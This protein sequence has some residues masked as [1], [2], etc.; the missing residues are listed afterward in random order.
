MK[1]LVLI[2]FIFPVFFLWGTIVNETVSISGG[3][4][5]LIYTYSEPTIE[6]SLD[7]QVVKDTLFT[8]LKSPDVPYTRMI[9]MPGEREDESLPPILRKSF[10][11]LKNKIA[12]TPHEKGFSFRDFK[13]L[14]DL[15]MDPEKDTSFIYTQRYM[16]NCVLT[17]VK[18]YMDHPDYQYYEFRFYNVSDKKLIYILGYV[19]KIGFVYAKSKIMTEDNRPEL[20][21]WTLEK[22]NGIPLKYFLDTPQAKKLCFL[23]DWG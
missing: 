20:R 23:E 17:S 8:R 5:P 19:N 15:N 11:C 22:I 18:N 7:Y 1:R 10:S 13:K 6:V 3:N 14:I 21:E 2:V 4:T 16:L 12:I 9:L